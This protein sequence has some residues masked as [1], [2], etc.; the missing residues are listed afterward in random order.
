[1]PAAGVPAVIRTSPRHAR[2]RRWRQ[3][4]APLEPTL[5]AQRLAHL[6]DQVVVAVGLAGIVA[7]RLRQV[8]I[9]DVADAPR[10]RAHDHHARGEE[11]RL[12]DGV[13]DED[14]GLAGRPPD[15]QHLRVEP[16]AGHLVE[17]PEGL[18]HQQ[19]GRLQ[20]QGAGDGHALLHATR[21]LMGIVVAERVQLHQ[22]QHLVDTRIALGT[23][24]PGDLQG[25][26]HVG[27]HAAPVEQHRRLEDDAV[28]A[29]EASLV[30]ALAVD[31]DGAGA[32]LDEVA[33]DTQQ[34]RLAAARG[35]DERDELAGLDVEVD[36]LQGDG[37]V[38]VL[39]GEDL[40]D[41]GKVDDGRRW[42]VVIGWPPGGCAG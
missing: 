20:R 35:T 38:P 24:D 22:L 6:G 26:A 19:Q 42:W 8:D 13:G 15:A 41:R 23:A 9:D 3:S 5:A 32:G 34:G 25:Q 14:D 18:V 16:L 7:P 27:L 10:P 28:V 11:D 30:R 40:V 33:H 21:Q 36:A 39:R 2:A 37:V 29:V 4:R 31:L 17:R 1:M 12:R